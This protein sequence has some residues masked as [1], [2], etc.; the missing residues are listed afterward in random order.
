[1]QRFGGCICIAVT[2]MSIEGDKTYNVKRSELDEMCECVICL[3]TFNDPVVLPCNHYFCR[4][5]IAELCGDGRF[6]TCPTCRED[7]AHSQAKPFKFYTNL[8]KLLDE[9][10]KSNNTA[11]LTGQEPKDT[12][13]NSAKLCTNW[14][15]GCSSNCGNF[16]PYDSCIDPWCPGNK[17]NRAHVVDWISREKTSVNEFSS[18]PR[19]I[20][21]NDI[22][23]P[24]PFNPFKAAKKLLSDN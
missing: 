19:T 16:H 14:N 1:M 22:G 3:E 4:K 23:N 11:N 12:H 15:T 5:C 7:F 13:K 20:K 10:E 21:A 17:C 24:D 8:R 2:S 9:G 6:Q 18:R